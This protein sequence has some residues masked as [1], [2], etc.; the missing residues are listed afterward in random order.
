MIETRRP[1]SG[2][3]TINGSRGHAT[4]YQRW[5][6][7]VRAAT[8]AVSH[9]EPV[10]I[11]PF[12][13]QAILERSSELT[14][15]EGLESELRARRGGAR[16]T[17]AYPT[18]ESGHPAAQRATLRR[19][20]GV[21]LAL[22]GVL[23]LGAWAAAG[24]LG[25]ARPEAILLAAIAV[26]G[27]GLLIALGVDESL[28]ALALAV[29]LSLGIE[30][31]GSL[32]MVWST[33]WHPVGMAVVLGG[34]SAGLLV[35]D[36]AGAGRALARDRTPRRRERRARLRAC[37]PAV[38]ALS[39][40]LT[41]AVL[42]ALSLPAIDTSHLGQYGLPPALPSS[43]Y[44]AL[45]LI[46]IGAT[47]AVWG[48][49]RS[50]WII[51]AYVLG[52]AVVLYATVPAISAVPQYSWVYKHIGVV[53]FIELHGHVNGSVDIYN[54]W[55]GFFALAASF[56]E[57]SGLRDPVAY[58]GWAELFFTTVAVLL[59]AAIAKALTRD[60]RIAGAAALVFL[61]AEW[62]G[63]TYF[64][65]Q[66]TGYVLSLTAL[67]VLFRTLATEAPH[68]RFV[69]FV[70]FASRRKQLPA[71]S[72]VRLPWP[73]RGAIAVVLGL[74][75]A[76]AATH[77]LTPYMLL[78][79]VGALGLL[80]V[81]GPRRTVFLGM[82]AITIG[83]LLPNLTY[84]QHNYGLFTSIDP[85]N[86]VQ[87]STLYDIAPSAGKVF[88][89]R[90]SQLL[91]YLLWLPGGLAALILAR[92]GLGRTALPV[93]ALA[94]TPFGVI[95]GNNYG[96]EAT[97]RVILFSSP[98]CAI[99][100]GW[101]ISTFRARAA[102]LLVFGALTAAMAVLFVPSFYG[103][104]ELNLLPSSEVSASQY[105][106]NH[107]PEGTVLMLSGPDFPIRQGKNYDRF[108]GP[109]GDDDPNLLAAN[110][111][112]YR[113]LGPADLPTVI[114][115]IEA[116]ARNGF[117]VFSSSQME[118]ASVFGL[119]PPGQLANLERAVA[120]S[121][122]F[123]LWYR[124]KDVR[125]YQLRPASSSPGRVTTSAIDLRSIPRLKRRFP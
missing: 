50:G 8:G 113:R 45:A 111:L 76:I 110:T 31:L 60:I 106:Y 72:P 12:V 81:I 57:L 9:P 52:L 27:G 69:R 119:T 90:T 2:R 49:R 100:I 120:G 53:R 103:M 86:N 67:L 51:G 114:S 89:A 66:A 83:Y 80:G 43:W 24:G 33:F 101:A 30:I 84:I 35:R 36:L 87:H 115:L 78:M 74:D 39:P 70:R 73:R 25:P 122:R 28:S 21:D 61:V 56:S 22:L 121:P 37:G 79:Q 48:P 97:L 64:A 58:A 109:K 95:F 42:W 18:P 94:L 14:R 41:A 7:Q 92:R 71:R 77:Q 85:F 5:C 19:R 116:Y 32:A 65:P 96:G 63:Q 107:A 16:R 40:L 26:P 6:D 123:R 125:I 11:E 46:V 54:R 55:P 4:L 105:F 38:A 108:L 98:G 124:N 47:I 13:E 75:F 44:G 104:A 99:L 1:P 59:I 62:V 10:E 93:A 17:G 34:G 68:E 15:R 117:L 102:R 91:T 3:R 88:N 23:V 82:L 118:Y 20:V 29:G 112:R